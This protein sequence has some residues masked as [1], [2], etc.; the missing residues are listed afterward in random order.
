[1]YAA[2][3]EHS[4]AQLAEVNPGGRRVAVRCFLCGHSRRKM[5]PL[6]AQCWH[7]LIWLCNGRLKKIYSTDS[8]P[9][10]SLLILLP[11]SAPQRELIST[12]FRCHD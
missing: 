9:I 4:V 7:S 10:E 11:Y 6:S 12:D 1:M 2:A 5:F 8:Y 3:L